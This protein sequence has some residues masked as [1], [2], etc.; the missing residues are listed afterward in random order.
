MDIPQN[1]SQ[2]TDVPTTQNKKNTP[3]ALGT[4]HR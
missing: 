2:P 3:T 4:K 1:N